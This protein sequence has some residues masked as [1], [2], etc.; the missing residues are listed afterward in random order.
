MEGWGVAGD[1]PTRDNNPG[2]ICAGSFTESEGALSAPGR[3][4]VFAT[5]DEGFK[6]LRDL[7]TR[8]YLGLTVAAALNR[9]A[10]PVENDSNLYIANVCKWTGLTA[11]TVLTAALIG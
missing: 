8:H 11:E 9:Y 10:P 7:L 4:A 6:A 5:P 1:L 2:D 3:F